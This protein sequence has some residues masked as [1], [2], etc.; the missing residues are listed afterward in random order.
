MGANWLFKILILYM[1][2]L[3]LTPLQV[4]LFGTHAKGSTFSP[5]TQYSDYLGV[6]AF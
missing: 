2:Q 3:K 1:T 5:A 6:D 4:G